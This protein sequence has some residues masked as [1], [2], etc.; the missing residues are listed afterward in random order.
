[1]TIAANADI[2]NWIN[3]ETPEPV[4][5]PALPIIDPHHH[6]WD[7]RKNNSM[8]FRQEVY[9]CEEISRE[10]AD[11]GHTIVQTLFAQ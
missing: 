1:M 10:I 5:E 7:L 8:G 9:L 4:L 6:L 11:S 2:E 3:R